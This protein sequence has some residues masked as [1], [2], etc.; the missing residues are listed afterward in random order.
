MTKEKH[1]RLHS[2]L[3]AH[4]RYDLDLNRK[5]LDSIVRMIQTGNDAFFIKRSSNGVTIWHVVYNKQSL[6][7]VYDKTRKSIVTFLPWKNKI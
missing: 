7:V 2:K 4:Q 1:Q 5:D 6:R 3:R